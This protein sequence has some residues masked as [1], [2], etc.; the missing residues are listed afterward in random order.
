MM[1]PTD[2]A[3]VSAAQAGDKTAFGHLVDR[4]QARAMSIALRMVADEGNAQDLTQEA[5]LQAYLSLSTLR[6]PSRFANWLFGVVRNVC[7][8][9]LRTQK[10]KW[11]WLAVLNADLVDPD[12]L[13]DDGASPLEE[14]SQQRELAAF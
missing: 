11:R 1:Q 14:L 5:I 4:Y 3:L 13:F 2:E 9:Y 8:T 7:A 10:A 12:L 6:E